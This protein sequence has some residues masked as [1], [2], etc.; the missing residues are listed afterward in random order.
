MYDAAMNPDVIYRNYIA[1]PEP[2][3]SIGGWIRSIFNF[4]VNV[5]VETN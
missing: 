2:I 1:G 3:T 4:G 5:S